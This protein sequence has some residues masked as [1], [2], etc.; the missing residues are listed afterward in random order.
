MET[1]NNCP[2]G[3]SYKDI[4]DGSTSTSELPEVTMSMASNYIKSKK[5]IGKCIG[6]GAV[7]C[8]LGATAL[9][10][11][12]LLFRDAQAVLLNQPNDLFMIG[13]IVMLVLIA[14][15]VALFVYSG[16]LESSF[17]YMQEP[18][19]M[20][21]QAKQQLQNEW[22]IIKPGNRTA[23]VVGVCLCVLSLIPAIVGFVIKDQNI[24]AL[25]IGVCS[26]L[27]I[28]ACVIYFLVNAANTSDAYN[29][30]LA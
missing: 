8:L 19:C 20:N 18:F 2:N 15:G 29:K 10:S 5:T 24:F 4:K 21:D 9:A 12:Q 27:I 1:A 13:L 22:E 25:G 17:E 6:L 14:G 26:T 28:I 30:L 7:L 16:K 3:M 23:M 11:S